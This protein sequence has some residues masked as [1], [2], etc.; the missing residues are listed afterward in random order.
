M[1]STLKSPPPASALPL[2]IKSQ[3]WLSGVSVEL[4]EIVTVRSALPAFSSSE[5]GTVTLL[6]PVNR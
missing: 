6:S 5:E 3:S 1:Y 4:R 2:R